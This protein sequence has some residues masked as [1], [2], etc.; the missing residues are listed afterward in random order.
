MAGVVDRVYILDV[1]TVRTVIVD[2]SS[3]EEQ[4]KEKLLAL[5]VE[6]SMR[7][8]GIPLLL[9]LTRRPKMDVE[10]PPN[11]K[12]ELLNTSFILPENKRRQ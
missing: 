5:D 10:I 11:Q 3:I 2:P 7:E 6:T 12:Q 9:L 8:C 4:A 1:T